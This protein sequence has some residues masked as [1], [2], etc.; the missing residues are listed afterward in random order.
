MFLTGYHGTT[1]SNAELILKNNYKISSGDKEWLGDGVYFYNELSDA[2]E[3]RE[4]EAILHSVIK[5]GEDEYLDIDSDE[6]KE[7]FNKIIDI[8]SKEYKSINNDPKYAVQNQC[9]IMK[10]IWKC[11]PKIM[12]ISASFAKSPTRYRTLLD[13]RP[14]RKEFCVRDNSCIKLTYL[15]RKDDLDD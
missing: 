9:A 12:A 15:I 13:T 2:Y 10:I 7:T 8:I 6:G 4:S 11:F 5:I 14:K 1:S 3:W